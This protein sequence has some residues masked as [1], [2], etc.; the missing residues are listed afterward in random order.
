MSARLTGHF[1]AREPPQFFVERPGGKFRFEA[2][3]FASPAGHTAA[4]LEWRVGRV[5]RRGWY[6]LDDYW[7]HDLKSG[8]ALDIPAEVFKESGDYR[9]RAR[10]R[11]AAG[12]QQRRQ[13]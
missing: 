1:V 11:D 9:V 2:S 12:T 4:A 6:E 13:T 8:R 3:E 5:G 7:L 10:W